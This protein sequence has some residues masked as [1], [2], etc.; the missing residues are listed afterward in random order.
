M[1]LAELYTNAR[2]DKLL[3]L[4]GN[5]NSIS[6]I[7]DF[8]QDVFLEALESEART[9]KDVEQ[10]AQR[11]AKR[12]SAVHACDDIDEPASILWEDNHLI[13]G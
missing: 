8:K 9:R 3:Q 4:L 11:V 13:Y 6:S 1:D 7:E 12:Y 10:C 5:K 2:F